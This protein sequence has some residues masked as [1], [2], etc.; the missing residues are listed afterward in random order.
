MNTQNVNVKTAA[1]ESSK[2]WVEKL[3]QN[4][5]VEKSSKLVELAKLEGRMMMYQAFYKM[6]IENADWDDANFIPADAAEIVNWLENT[7]SINSPLVYELILA[8]ES[9]AIKT[10]E[11]NW[12]HTRKRG[13]VPF[14]VYKDE[15]PLQREAYLKETRESE[16]RFSITVSGR[17]EYRD[18]EPCM[19][20]YF[21]DGSVSLGCVNTISEAMHRAYEAWTNKNWNL[22]D[23]V[24]DYYD[25]D[26]GYDCGPLSF[27]PQMII[28]QDELGR[29]VLRGNASSCSWYDHVTDVK[30]IEQIELEKEKLNQEAA[31][32]SGWDNYET[33][34]QLR[35]RALN[36]CAGVVDIAWRGHP[37]VTK[38]I[39]TFAEWS[40]NEFI[41]YQ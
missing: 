41:S 26:L 29:V 40:F 34:R 12:K 2:T 31:Y 38:A 11:F 17:K 33:A 32:E 16:F 24:R 21:S 36:L 39:S 13:Y 8:V 3:T 23:P 4:L 7:G 15:A 35:Q 10:N 27:I 30:R 18:T 22:R 20:T 14:D 9:L 37:D 6:D 25:P 28:I 1:S 5:L 19:P